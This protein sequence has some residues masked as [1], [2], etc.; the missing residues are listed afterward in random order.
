MQMHLDEI[1]CNVAA[2][3]ARRRPDALRYLMSTAPTNS[4]SRRQHSA[5]SWCKT[6]LP[7]KILV[8]N[9]WQYLRSRPAA[10]TANFTTD[11]DGSIRGCCSVRSLEQ[12]HRSTRDHHVRRNE[13]LCRTQGNNRRR[14]GT[15][16]WW[17]FVRGR[18]PPRLC[19]WRMP[20]ARLRR[21]A[22]SFALWDLRLRLFPVLRLVWAGACRLRLDRARYC[23]R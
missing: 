6:F 18:A 14:S 19:G 3:A 16:N 22:E 15:P 17:N 7:E 10:Q 20:Y 2:T 9:F 5:S 8:D 23:L 4:M 21:G 11:Y 13:R 1:S 12:A